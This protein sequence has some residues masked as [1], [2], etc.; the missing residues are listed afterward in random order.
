MLKEQPKIVP[1][2]SNLQY[3]LD[4]IALIALV[5]FLVY[6]LIYWPGLPERVPVHFDG[7]GNP[8]SYG[9]KTTLLLLPL[10]SLILFFVLTA[11]NKRPDLFNYPVKITEENAERQYTLAR[12]M[13]SGLNAALIIA[14]FF[15]AWKTGMLVQGKADGL[16]PW[17]LPVF[18]G[19]TMGPVV[20]YM[21]MAFRK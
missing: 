3:T 21:I 8:N 20:I 14:F 19:I 6:F 9:N 18:L 2:K 10:I 11:I 4:R 17:F 7:A 12:N 16:G 15:L 1:P 5:C 13:V